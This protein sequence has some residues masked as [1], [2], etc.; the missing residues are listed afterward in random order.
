MVLADHDGLHL[1]VEDDGVGFDVD[2]LRHLSGRF[3]LVSMRERAESLG[4]TFT[5]S[6]RSTVG[7]TV[8]VVLP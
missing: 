4:G 6:S 3:G 8:E 5:V 1:R 7:T 2:D